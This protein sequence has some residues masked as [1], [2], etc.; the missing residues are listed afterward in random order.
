MVPTVSLFNH[1]QT[2]K[3][4]IQLKTQLWELSPK[5]SIRRWSQL[6]CFLTSRKQLAR[7]FWLPL[8]ISLFSNTQAKKIRINLK[9]LCLQSPSILVPRPR[10]LRDE[11][12]AMGTIMACGRNREL[13]EQPFWNNKGN[14]RILPI[15]SHVVCTY[16]ACLK[17]LLPE[18]SIPAAGQKDHRLWR[19]EWR[20]QGSTAVKRLSM[21]EKLRGDRIARFAKPYMW[22]WRLRLLV[23]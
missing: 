5:S 8:K 16:G 17:W 15:R 14:N 9:I 2:L 18:L 13:W 7:T 20:D 23:S 11:K 22:L 6:F 1:R 3:F 10:R 12:R 19:R 21:R 4:L